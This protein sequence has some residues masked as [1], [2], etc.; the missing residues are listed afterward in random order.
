MVGAVRVFDGE[1]RL[2]NYR[3]AFRQVPLVTAISILGSEDIRRAD[4]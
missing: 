3:V 1:E 2:D 4:F